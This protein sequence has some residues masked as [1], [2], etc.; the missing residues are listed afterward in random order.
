MKINSAYYWGAA[1]KK[2]DFPA[3]NWPEIILVG[4]SNVGKSSLINCLLRRRR[5]AHTSN[6]PGKTCLLHFYAINDSFFLVDAPGYGY[7]RVSKEK[8]RQWAFLLVPYL[9]K[10]KT[11]LGALQLVDMRHP[12]IAGD[13]VMVRWLKSKNLPFIVIANKCDKISRGQQPRHLEMIRSR[14]DLVPDFPVISFSALKGQGRDEVWQY[15]KSWL[16]V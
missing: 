11:L 14:L 13:E 7:A 1:A 4:R 12:P 2:Q 8:R 3:E 5:L 10:R 9:E 16:L 15:L 6:T